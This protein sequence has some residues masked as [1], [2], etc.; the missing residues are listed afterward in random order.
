M[1]TATEQEEVLVECA[2]CHE[3]FQKDKR[4]IRMYASTFDG[5]RV[6]ICRSCKQELKE[7]GF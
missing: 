4:K 2:Y 6:S 3:W 5:T 1:T 7:L